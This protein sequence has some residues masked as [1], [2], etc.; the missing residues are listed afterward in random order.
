MTPSPWGQEGVILPDT[1]SAP[2]G[3]GTLRTSAMQR[4]AKLTARGPGSSRRPRRPRRGNAKNSWGQLA[5]R[6]VVPI[7]FA[8]DA[9][10]PVPLGEKAPDP[11]ELGSTRSIGTLAEGR[12]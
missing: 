3:M 7:S 10:R 1:P 5:R 11:S 8:N 6:P 12:Q 2:L 4:S 9:S